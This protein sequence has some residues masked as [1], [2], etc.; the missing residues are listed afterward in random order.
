MVELLVSIAIVAI[1]IGGIYTSFTTQHNVH[2]AQ[3]QVVQMQQNIRAAMFI[4]EKE[5]RMAGYDASIYD[6]DDF[7]I[8]DVRLRQLDGTYS[9]SGNSAITYTADDYDGNGSKTISI[10]KNG[11]TTLAR[12][13]NDG[14]SQL[15]ADNVQAFAMAYAFD[16]GDPD[17]DLELSANN[18][19]IWAV[20][21]DNDNL[22]DL[23]LD[24]NDDGDITIADD[25]DNDNVIDGTTLTSFVDV[26]DIR[27]IRIW[28]LGRT[29]IASSDYEEEGIYVIGRNIVRTDDGI[30]RR[31]LTSIVKC[32]NMGE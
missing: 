8:T 12:D 23:N 32:R 21:T 27:A 6:T 29:E 31:R 30:R 4:L 19:I 25:T 5:L 9:S 22:L 3:K 2:Q 11:D 14:G 16:D 24:T 26:E 20:D 7:G 17:D 1:V 13:L 28:M 10:F 18:N 15:L